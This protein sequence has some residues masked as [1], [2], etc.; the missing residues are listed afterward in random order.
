MQ[1]YTSTRNR[2][3]FTLIELLVVIAIIAI[4]AAILF[5]VFAKA[6]E[7]ARQTSCASN[8][9]QLGLAIIQYQQDADEKFP[10]GLIPAAA[11]NPDGPIGNPS[12]AGVGWGGDILV[13]TRSTG[14]FKCP[15]DSTAGYMGFANSYAMNEFLPSNSLAVLDGPA[16]TVLLYEVTGDTA[17]VGF[18]DELTT[19]RGPYEVSAVGTGWPDPGANA[20][21]QASVVT[22]DGNDNCTLNNPQFVKPAVGGSLARHDQGTGNVNTGSA[23]Y[24]MTDGHVKFLKQTSVSNGR[25]PAPLNSLNPY[26]ATFNYKSQ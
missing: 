3:G 11:P 17:G 18:P 21:D 8:E 26:T 7:K 10:S 13:Y 25:Q 16:N 9:K 22:C 24:L 12:G 4:L 6:R 20:T 15:D 5:P 2:G 1:N 14:I 23:N 19:S